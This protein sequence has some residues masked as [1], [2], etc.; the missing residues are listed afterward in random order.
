ME[1][2][3]LACHGSRYL[4]MTL[5][6]MQITSIIRHILLIDWISWSSMLEGQK[7]LFL[8][9]FLSYCVQCSVSISWSLAHPKPLQKLF[10]NKQPEHHW[11]CKESC[12]LI[13]LWQEHGLQRLDTP[14]EETSPSDLLSRLGIIKLVKCKIHF[15]KFHT[16]LHKSLEKALNNCIT[17]L[18]WGKWG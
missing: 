3:H 11:N 15:Y 9:V 18:K 14:L 16:N 6:I 10:P 12:R 8:S 1:W 7:C 4:H 17:E 2:L 5:E 13:W